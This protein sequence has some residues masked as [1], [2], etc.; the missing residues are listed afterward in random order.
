ME[1]WDR[2]VLKAVIK[3]LAAE[4][5]RERRRGWPT[6]NGRAYLGAQARLCLLAYALLRGKAR[7][8]L[9]SPGTRKV[10]AAALLATVL[11]Y[12]GWRAQRDWTLETV[13]AWC[14]AGA[15]PAT[16]AA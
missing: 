14:E 9:E 8:S 13:T 11:R 10:P 6:P 16:A 4:A 5:R 3:G 15:Q 2:L 7:A 12:G 1:R